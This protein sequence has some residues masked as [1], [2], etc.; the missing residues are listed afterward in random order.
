[1]KEV[2]PLSTRQRFI[3]RWLSSTLACLGLL[4][5]V[6]ADPPAS[7]DAAAEVYRRHGLDPKIPLESRVATTPASVLSQLREA[8]QP[9]PQEHVLIAAQRLQLNAAI[10]SLPPLHRRILGARLRVLSFLDGMPNTALTSTVNPKESFR[11]FDITV[12]ARILHENVSEWLT[13]KEQTC[14]E[15]KGS[16]LRVY[17]DAGTKVDAL[18]Y[19]LLHEATHIV[20]SCERITPP[21]AGGGKAPRTAS[22]PATPFTEGI[23]NDVTLPVALYRDPLR[24]RVLFYVDCGPLP[25]N[26]AP[27]LYEYLR[28]TPF[29]SLYGGRN[30]LDDLA[31]YVSVY[32]LTEVLKQPYRI[33]LRRG[34]AE[35]FAYEP[36]KSQLVRRRIG[37]MKRY[38]AGG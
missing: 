28:R 20:D 6:R 24:E 32:H 22:R 23:W 17:V 35:I 34:D 4:N 8:D 14:F 12:N 25:I 27:D 29:A 9:A 38:Y 15:A 7:Q 18:V 13:K 3:L 30:W 16:P 33:V 31:E 36:M 2:W 11:L 19:V 5:L 10:Q 26:H 37:Q 1:M 21:L